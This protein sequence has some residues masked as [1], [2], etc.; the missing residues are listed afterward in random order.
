MVRLEKVI[1]EKMLNTKIL[2]RA[3]VIKTPKNL[4]TQ[5]EVFLK[6]LPK[7]RFIQKLINPIITYI[8]SLEYRDWRNLCIQ[9]GISF[10]QIMMETD[11]EL[12]RCPFHEHFLRETTHPYHYSLNKW[13]R[14][15]YSKIDTYLRGFEAP[16]HIKNEV[17]NRTYVDCKEKIDTFHEM[18]A[19]NYNNEKTFLNHYYRGSMVILELAI[20]YNS[21][22]RIA[23]NRLFYNEE[24]YLDTK[25]W[26][27]QQIHLFDTIKFDMNNDKH[28]EKYKQRL[29]NF[30]K[31]YP[32]Y[33]APDGE[34][35]DYNKYMNNN[36]NNTN[37]SD[38]N[39]NDKFTVKDFEG[40]DGTFKNL[41]KPF[42]L[43]HLDDNVV[44][45]SEELSGQ[46][47]VGVDLP[48]YLKPTH[49]QSLMN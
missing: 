45:K 47:N 13:S 10:D 42:V 15:A 14:F 22:M 49:G 26:L 38:N 39:N 31:L 5:Q 23:W 34:K 25:E 6:Q 36:N 12:Y 1:Y 17:K 21:T 27:K 3:R 32:G 29:D 24:M 16:D 48:K 11:M 30:N 43:D 20:F 7:N 8:D 4:E 28:I 19:K 46:N 35:V 44:E 37:N 40:L 33:L 9:R 2:N 41:N 18:L